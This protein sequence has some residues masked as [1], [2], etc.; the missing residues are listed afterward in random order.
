MLATPVRVRGR[1]VSVQFRPAVR[2][3]EPD[4]DMRTLLFDQQVLVS[5]LGAENPF[6]LDIKKAAVCTGDFE[7]RAILSRPLRPYEINLVGFIENLEARAFD[8]FR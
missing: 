8:L 2:E 5:V 6:S 1:G 4:F 3:D 7:I